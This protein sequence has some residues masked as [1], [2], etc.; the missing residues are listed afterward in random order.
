MVGR[1]APFS[2]ILND[3]YPR[4]QGRAIIWCWISEKGYGI[5]L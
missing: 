4:F 1:T 3:F 2:M 5:Q